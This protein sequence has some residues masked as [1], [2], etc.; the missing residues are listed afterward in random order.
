[1]GPLDRLDRLD[2]LGAEDALKAGPL[3]AEAA[4]RGDTG[5][6]D[7]LPGAC[8]LSVTPPALRA[9]GSGAMST[10]VV[11]LP[12]MTRCTRSQVV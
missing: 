11:S 9:M 12:S 4:A 6:R 8:T 3:A 7:T 10:H 2:A 5:P 1:M